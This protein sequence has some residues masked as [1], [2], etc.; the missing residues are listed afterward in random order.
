[1][2]REVEEWKLIENCKYHECSDHGRF[3][4]KNR[5]VACKGG[6]LRFVKGKIMKVSPDSQGYGK[7]MVR[8]GERSI[9]ISAHIVVYETHN[10]P[11]PPGYTIDHDD[12]D[13]MN[14][15]AW[16]L[17]TMTDVENVRKMMRGTQAKGKKRRNIA[18]LFGAEII[19]K[20]NQGSRMLD[21]ADEYNVSG[22][23]IEKIIRGIRGNSSVKRTKK[24]DGVDT[25]E[26]IKMESR[27]DSY[28]KIAETFGKSPDY[29]RQLCYKSRGES[30]RYKINKFMA[31]DIRRK[32]SNGCSAKDLSIEYG[33]TP[34]YISSIC[35]GKRK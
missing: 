16:N 26:M 31:Q 35:S 8:R 2:S 21:L 10:G 4:S 30:P 23:Y 28:Q 13:K 3:R 7:L 1:M 20:Y 17:V 25:D 34:G 9:T 33:V 22:S 29:I 6:G 19:E 11:I 18:T 32:R 27:G 14:N 5:S 24:Y 12:N 15:A